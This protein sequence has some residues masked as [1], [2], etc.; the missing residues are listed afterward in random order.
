MVYEITNGGKLVYVSHSDNI[1][2]PLLYDTMSVY[3][4][5]VDGTRV[6]VDIT[7]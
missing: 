3:A 6:K 2:L 7:M 1:T 5:A 4:V